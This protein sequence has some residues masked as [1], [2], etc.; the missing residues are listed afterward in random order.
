MRPSIRARS[1]SDSRGL[2]GRRLPRGGTRGRGRDAARLQT[3]GRRVSRCHRAGPVRRRR[4]RPRRL[5]LRRLLC[6][7]HQSVTMGRVV[8]G[9]QGRCSPGSRSAPGVG[10]GP[11]DRCR[12]GPADLRPRRTDRRRDLR[13]RV[14]R[15]LPRSAGPSS[16]ASRTR[17][18]LVAAPQYRCLEPGLAT[19]EDLAPHGRSGG[20]FPALPPLGVRD[21]GPDL[22]QS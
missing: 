13:G 21:A 5:F 1:G 8:L 3:P 15:L 20:S 7:P 6:G 2:G 17:R 9:S 12:S 11:G 4:D 18:V 22:I 14:R 16:G 19:G 10:G